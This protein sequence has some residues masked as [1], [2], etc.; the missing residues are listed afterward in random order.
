MTYKQNKTQNSG[1]ESLLTVSSCLYAMK[2]V[3]D[4]EDQREHQQSESE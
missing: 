1:S 4:D 2:G 3:Q